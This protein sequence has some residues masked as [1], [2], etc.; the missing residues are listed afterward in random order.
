MLDYQKEL[1]GI[2]EIL[3]FS[4]K[5]QHKNTVNSFNAKLQLYDLSE[6]S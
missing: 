5:H 3:S 2:P 1:N 6:K 4:Q